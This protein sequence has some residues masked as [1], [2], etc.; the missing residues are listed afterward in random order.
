MN[1]N[2]IKKFSKINTEKILS[3]NFYKKR[4]FTILNVNQNLAYF[5]G[6]IVTISI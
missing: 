1:K 6:K 4:V 3:P 2:K 5:N